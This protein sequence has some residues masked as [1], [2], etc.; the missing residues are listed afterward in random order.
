MFDILSP[1]F[2]EYLTLL[3]MKTRI[4]TPPKQHRKECPKCHR[5]LVT[6]YYQGEKIGYLCNECQKERVGDSSD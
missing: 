3:K 4:G 6:L 1:Y 2:D 5:K